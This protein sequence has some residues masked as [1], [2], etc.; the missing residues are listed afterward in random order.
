MCC[1]TETEVAAQTFYLTQSQYT[2]TWPTSPSSDPTTPGRVPTWVPIFKSLVWLDLQKSCGKWDLNPRSSAL[3]VDTLTTRPKRWLRERK[4]ERRGRQWA[5]KR[6]EQ[7]RKRKRN[8][9]TGWDKN[10]KKE[11]KAILRHKH[12]VIRKKINRDWLK[13]KEAKQAQSSNKES[14]CSNDPYSPYLQDFLESSPSHYQPSQ[15]F[16]LLHNTM[17]AQ[18]PAFPFPWDFDLWST[19]HY[20]PYFISRLYA[21]ASYRENVDKRRNY[22]ILSV[23]TGGDRD[24]ITFWL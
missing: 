17:T 3:E 11:E 20:Q 9:G 14:K 23:V 19:M 24:S 16:R 7:T 18:V 15:T 21:C 5:K 2:D 6:M 22:A 10:R 1:D 13:T 8:G 4:R 12:T